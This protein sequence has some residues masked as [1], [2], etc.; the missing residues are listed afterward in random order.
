MKKI[1]LRKKD[2]INSKK[3]AALITVIMVLAALAVLTT[4]II[5]MAY[6]EAMQ[7]KTQ[8]DFTK[9]SFIAKSGAEIAASEIMSNFSH[10]VENTPPPDSNIALDDGAFDIALSVMR[11]PA[12]SYDTIIIKSTGLYSESSK[13]LY[14]ELTH[15]AGGT[16][17]KTWHKADPFP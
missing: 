17:I 8:H 11:P 3:G 2:L 15:D 6:V 9:A 12:V 1:A 16:L 5:T 13:T 7:A 4:A 10:Y 14:L